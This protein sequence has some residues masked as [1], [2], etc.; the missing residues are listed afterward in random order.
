MKRWQGKPGLKG[1]GISAVVLLAVLEI[2]LLSGNFNALQRY[3]RKGDEALAEGNYGLALEQYNLALKASPNNWD[4]EVKIAEVMLAQKDWSQADNLLSSLL[5]RD[6]GRGKSLYPLLMQSKLA[7]AQAEIAKQ[8]QGSGLARMYLEEALKYGPDNQQ[9]KQ[10]LAE[11]LFDTVLGKP[12]GLNIQTLQKIVQLDPQAK[13][14]L[15]LASMYLQL[16]RPK[17]S[18]KPWVH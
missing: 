2:M 11:Q 14:K 17:N 9:V 13:Y 10:L 8:P 6:A 18:S 7:L 15:E 3:T 4:V 12:A 1:L 5:A 16:N